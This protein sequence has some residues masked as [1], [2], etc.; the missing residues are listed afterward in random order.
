[1]I[2][3]P[4]V[5]G[6]FYPSDPTRLIEAIRGCYLGPFGPGALPPVPESDAEV[7]ACVAPH[8]GYEYSGQVAAH[9][10]LHASSLRKPD[11]LIVV[12]PN[13][14]GSG[15]GV[16]T[17]PEGGWET[18]IGRIPIARSA[19]RELVEGTRIV[20]FDAEAHALEHSVEV[21]VPFLQH[22]FGGTVPLLPVSLLH[23]DI[24]TAVSVG[25]GL[26]RLV[27]GKRAVVVASS[28]FTHYEPY[29]VACEKDGEMLADVLNLD[30]EEFYA[31]LEKLEGTA[32]G[33]GAV[34]AVMK[35]ATSLGF[36]KGELLKYA[37][38]GDTSGDKSR[39]VGYASVRFVK[40]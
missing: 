18:P 17:F 15:S 13:H 19:A 37:N 16:A 10:Y 14:Y 39:V 33:H 27:K 22:L 8:A 31:T 20:A 9:A 32:C 38:S 3:K 5:A 4:S 12:G 36:L 7:V 29:E 40:K 24:E 21:H 11:L 35:A 25:E 1:M 30:V 34:A 6:S 26:A 2:R 28:D 23:Q